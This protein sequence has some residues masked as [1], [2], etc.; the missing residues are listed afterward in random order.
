MSTLHTINKSPFTH[1]TLTSCL[2]VCSDADSILLIE[3]ATYAGAADTPLAEAMQRKID[4]GVKIYALESDAH[5]RGL[6]KRLR[7]D[8]ELTDYQGFVRLSCEHQ[9][10]QS[11]F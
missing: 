6:Q 7:H 3:D 9:C 4:S 11:W 2:A 8:I 5:A 10:I 1:T